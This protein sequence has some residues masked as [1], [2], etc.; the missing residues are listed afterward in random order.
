MCTKTDYTSW[1]HTHF[2]LISS[3]PAFQH[4]LKGSSSTAL[5]EEL[6]L[7]ESPWQSQYPW[8][9]GFWFRRRQRLVILS[10]C[11]SF[12][13]FAGSVGCSL[14]FTP[15]IWLDCFDW[16]S[17]TWCQLTWRT[18]SIPQQSLFK[19][20]IHPLDPILRL[21][22]W[23]TWQWC[24]I[25]MDMD[26]YGWY[27]GNLTNILVVAQSKYFTTQSALATSHHC[28][29]QL[30]GEVLWEQTVRQMVF[31]G[32]AWSRLLTLRLIHLEHIHL[33]IA[34]AAFHSISMIFIV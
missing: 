13:F 19:T 5:L 29:R 1:F 18:Y 34:Q 10:L 27:L 14:P 15:T 26:G 24:G 7:Y 17:T 3:F 22:L 31:D 28:L 4:P 30:T 33:C 2:I 32:V 11:T 8:K 6:W 16:K 12:A 20:H 25:W 23:C 21:R 9:H